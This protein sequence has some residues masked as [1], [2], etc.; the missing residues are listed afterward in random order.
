MISSLSCELDVDI[1]VAF[2]FVFID[3][4]SAV[5]LYIF[6]IFDLVVAVVLDAFELL[7]IVVVIVVAA[8]RVTVL[9][10]FV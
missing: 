10:A 5:P 8:I 9:D 1:L 7:V 3:N 2:N 6:G 4:D